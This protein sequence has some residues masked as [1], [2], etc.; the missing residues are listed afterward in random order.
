VWQF[1]FECCPQVLEISSVADQLSCF[2]V[3]FSLCWFTGGFFL[4]LTLFLCGQVSDPSASSLLS[5]C[6]D[7][8][9]I[10]FSILQCYLTFD[11]AY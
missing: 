6:C 7:G 9:L 5:G 4:F 11:V 2:V 3:G 1:K 10:V 8:L